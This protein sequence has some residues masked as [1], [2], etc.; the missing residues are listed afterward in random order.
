M[1]IR[2]YSDIH[3]DHYSTKLWYP[4]ELPDDKDTILVLAGDLWIGTKWIEC[5]NTGTRWVSEPYTTSWIY[6][7]A[8]RFKQVLVVLGNH[9]YWP[10][11]G[12]RLTI[13]DGAEK[14]N[15]MLKDMWI[16][17]VHVLDCD[18]FEI[19]DYLFIGCTLWTDMAKGDLLVMRN[20]PN[21]IAYDGKIAFDTSPAVW[22]RFT[23]E[24]WCKTHD[25]H[26]DYIKHVLE[27]NQDKKCIVI[28]HHMPLPLMG[29]PSYTGDMCN[30]YYFSDLS[31]LIL[32]NEN[33][34]MWVCGHSHVQLDEMFGHCRLYMNSVGYQSEHFEQQGRVK[35]EVIKI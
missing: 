26:R 13:V 33:C 28:T 32:D 4:P 12:G 7:L 24:L 22:S 23:S 17:N 18:T 34:K 6:E 19:D 14:C 30:A 31:D 11:Q 10:I 3:Q 5:V 15:D 9:D 1:K 25:V 29:H 21:S 35:H 2:V 16:N 27:Q 8:L 20:M